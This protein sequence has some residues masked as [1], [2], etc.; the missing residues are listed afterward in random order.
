M[1]ALPWM[2][3]GLVQ[4][5]RA[6]AAVVEFV[7]A[8]IVDHWIGISLTRLIAMLV[9]FIV[10]EQTVGLQMPFTWVHFWAVLAAV[11]AAFGK[12]VWVDFLKRNKNETAGSQVFETVEVREIRERREG[13]DFE[14]TP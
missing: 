6:L 1:K 5:W 10:Y 8:P 14:A 7:L 2:W 12:T 4:L 3:K 9:V 13:K 11:S